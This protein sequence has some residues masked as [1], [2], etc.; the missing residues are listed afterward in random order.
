MA[1][2]VARPPGLPAEIK[3]QEVPIMT[4]RK[5]GD[6]IKLDDVV[7]IGEYRG[8][9]GSCALLRLMSAAPAGK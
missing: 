2:C 7:H 9:C 5:C 8:Y 6:P 4:C 1:V 3:F